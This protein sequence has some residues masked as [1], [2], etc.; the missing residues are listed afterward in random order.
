[1]QPDPIGYADGLNL[2]AYAR[3]DPVNL[4][5]PSGMAVVEPNPNTLPI[6]PQTCTG[7]L[8][9]RHDCSDIGGFGVAGGTTASFSSTSGGYVKSI[10][11]TIYVV[12]SMAPGMLTL[13]ELRVGGST[14]F[15]N[16]PSVSFEPI[17][18][19]D[20]C[21]SSGLSRYV[22]DSPGGNDVSAACA[23]HDACYAS[24][25]SRSTCDT[26]FLDDVRFACLR[27]GG[28]SNACTAIA[29]A[30][31]LAVRIFARGAYVGRGDPN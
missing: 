3:G 20:S 6:D 9:P 1:M 18:K 22:P 26:R 8:I 7:S 11:D 17:A 12:Q 19:R 2:Y 24:S 31:Y 27:S 21:G 28:S 29:N 10:G 4:V 16:L 14:I 25:S 15:E 13:G 23:I 30:Y 5:D